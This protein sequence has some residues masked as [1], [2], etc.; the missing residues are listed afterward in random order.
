MHCIQFTRLCCTRPQGMR[1]ATI[2]GRA[3]YFSRDQLFSKLLLTLTMAAGRPTGVTR[4]SREA[5][6]TRG[7]LRQHVS[8]GAAIVPF[9]PRRAL[10]RAGYFTVGAP[11]P[12]RDDD[13]VTH[14]FYCT[15]PMLFGH[16][17]SDMA[18]GAQL[19]LKQLCQQLNASV[20]AVSG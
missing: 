14:R 16:G 1:L 6:A 13:R 4:A 15:Q 8:R 9:V 20:A 2:G 12:Q 5:P 19:M 10:T 11:S 3:S 17:P 7:P 18:H